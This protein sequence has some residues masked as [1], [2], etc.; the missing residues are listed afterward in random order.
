MADKD[1]IGLVMKIVKNSFKL[2]LDIGL[3][4]LSP[5]MAHLKS[6]SWKKI[7]N[8]C[9]HFFQFSLKL[10]N[11]LVKFSDELRK[12]ASEDCRSGLER[13]KS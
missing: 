10:K 7:T 2:L 9:V 4:V 5:N 12:T 6:K 11:Y 3:V 13:L 1:E 8:M